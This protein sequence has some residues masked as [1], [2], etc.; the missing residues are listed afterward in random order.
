RDT[1][2]GRNELFTEHTFHGDYTPM[3]AVRT[4]K[5]K[6]ILNF[7]TGRHIRSPKDGSKQGD[8]REWELNVKNGP[9]PLQEL[10]DLEE[11][12]EETNN[13]LECK[14]GDSEAVG[15][16]VSELRDKLYNWMRKTKDPLLDGPIEG[17]REIQARKLLK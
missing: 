7:Y 11:D 8:F 6:Y 4:E 13:L 2:T 15:A 12:P 5:Y 3:R 17:P 10:Y 9:A 14:N 16:T 1:N